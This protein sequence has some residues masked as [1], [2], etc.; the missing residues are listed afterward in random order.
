MWF[1][2]RR[3]RLRKQV[4]STVHQSSGYGA[5]VSYPTAAASYVLHGSSGT[6]HSHAATTASAA[7]ASLPA[8]SHPVHPQAHGQ[9]LVDSTFS[10]NQGIFHIFYHNYISFSIHLFHIIFIYDDDIS[11]IIYYRSLCNVASTCSSSC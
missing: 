2:N 5:S 9:S 11:R 1:S 4:Q 7:A 3:A 6:G 10:S 8:S